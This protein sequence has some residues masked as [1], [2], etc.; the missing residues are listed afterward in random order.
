M[1]SPQIPNIGSLEY[2]AW[3]RLRLAI[4]AR[5]KHDTPETRRAVTAARVVFVEACGE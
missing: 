2:R 1:Q 5:L 3:E 4:E